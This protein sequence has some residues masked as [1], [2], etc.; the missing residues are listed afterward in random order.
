MIEIR[1]A[2][3]M[4]APAAWE[5][6][7]TAI[8]AQCVGHYPLTSL[9]AWTDGAPGDKWANLV[10]ER[11]FYVALH[12]GS[13][14]ATGMLTPSTRQVDA[15]FVSPSHMGKG[16]GRHMLS[17]IEA[18]ATDHALD[19]LRLDATLNAASFYRRF[20]WSGEAIST[21]RSPGGLELACIPMTK[22]I[23]AVIPTSEDKLRP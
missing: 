4:D 13:V 5:I 6:R 11:D 8:L 14:A 9:L 21:Y 22:T 3:R 1:R 12:E 19:S 10:A 2:T 20:G 23:S 18:R 16:L 7:K 15:I 17:F